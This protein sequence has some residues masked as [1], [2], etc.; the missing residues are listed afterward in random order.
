MSKMP[1]FGAKAS[2]YKS[3]G[4]Y[5]SAAVSSTQTTDALYPALMVQE[6]QCDTSCCASSLLRESKGGEEDDDA[7]I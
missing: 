7:G 6:T 5:Q 2:L 1:G 4:R 3:D